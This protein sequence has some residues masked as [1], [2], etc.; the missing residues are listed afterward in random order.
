MESAGLKIRISE[1]NREQDTDAAFV[2]GL[3]VHF[4]MIRFIYDF[5]RRLSK[6]R[7]FIIPRIGKRQL[8]TLKRNIDKTLQGFINN[9]RY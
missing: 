7:D 6:F 5:V 3:R 1:Q 8:I 2:H 4:T 9:Y